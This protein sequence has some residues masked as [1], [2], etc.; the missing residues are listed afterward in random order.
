MDGSKRLWITLGA[1]VLLG[2]SIL[3]FFGIE[4]YRQAPPMPE[5]IASANSTNDEA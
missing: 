5:R 2:F 4:V 1:T 3:G